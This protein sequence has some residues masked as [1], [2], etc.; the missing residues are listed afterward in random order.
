VP[1]AIKIPKPKVKDQGQ[2]SSRFWPPLCSIETGVIN[3]P[4]I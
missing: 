4:E 3:F 1:T 2:R